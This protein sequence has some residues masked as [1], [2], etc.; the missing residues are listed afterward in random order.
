MN[1]PTWAFGDFEDGWRIEIQRLWNLHHLP[2]KHWTNWVYSHGYESSHDFSNKNNLLNLLS[3]VV[4]MVIHN[5][6]P[7]R[8]VCRGCRQRTWFRMRMRFVTIEIVT[9]N[10]HPKR[11]LIEPRPGL[12]RA[13]HQAL[14]RTSE[15]WREGDQAALIL[16]MFLLHQSGVREMRRLTRKNV[17]SVL[18]LHG[19]WTT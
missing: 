12:R 14:C 10:W 4:G 3:N 2:D 11:S 9:R 7:W 6:W 8:P 18:G 13:R 17:P 16:R 19:S 5:S 1:R 15:R